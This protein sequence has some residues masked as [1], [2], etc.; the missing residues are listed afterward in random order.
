MGKLKMRLIGPSSSSKD[1]KGPL[2][3]EQIQEQK[4]QQEM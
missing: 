2:S 4:Q 3:Q 1:G